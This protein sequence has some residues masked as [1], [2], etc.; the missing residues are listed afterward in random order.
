MNRQEKEQWIDKLL[1]YMNDKI[2]KKGVAVDKVVCNFRVDGND[3]INFNKIYPISYEDILT[4]INTCISRRLCLYSEKTLMLTSSGSIRAL[5]VTLK[6][7]TVESSS[8]DIHIG[9]INAS[10]ATQIGNYNTQNIERVFSELI[11]KI[12]ASDA[13]ETEKQEAKSRL[14]AFLEHPLVGT[15]L[16]LGG[17]ILTS[18]LGG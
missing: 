9:T 8:G 15:A 4:V 3:Y 14:I 1:I 10:G 5:K 12:D 18:L 2:E 13:P 17:S 6:E 7:E 11:E 16:G